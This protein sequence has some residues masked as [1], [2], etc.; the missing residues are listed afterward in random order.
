[1]TLLYSV[2]RAFDA[3]NAVSGRVRRFQAGETFSCDAK[4][5]SAEGTV[6]IEVNS[7]YFLVDRSILELCSVFKNDGAAPFF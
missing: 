2:T 5:T 4:A 3:T 6:T 1:M 7:S